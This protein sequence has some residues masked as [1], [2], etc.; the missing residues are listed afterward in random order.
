MRHIAGK[1]GARLTV[2]EGEAAGEITPAG[3]T[4]LS[5]LDEIIGDA[6]S[7]VTAVFDWRR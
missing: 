3:P 4:P 5:L 2:A 7:F 1:F 6:T